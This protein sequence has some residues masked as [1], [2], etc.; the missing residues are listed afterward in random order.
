VLTEDLFD[1]FVEARLTLPFDQS[2]AEKQ[3]RMDAALAGFE[4][5]VA[6]QVSDVT[7]AATYYIAE[8]YFDFSQ[9]LLDSERPDDLSAAELVEY[10]LVLE[11]HAFPFEEQAIDVHEQNFALLANGVFNPWVARSLG[12]LSEVMPG[13]YAK[14]EIST[15]FV[16]SVDVYAY[17]SPG[18]PEV[19]SGEAVAEDA[20]GGRDDF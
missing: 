17:R 19:D 6:Y 9:S 3:Q 2:L 11:E 14:A 1:R 20:G 18:A 7:A 5:L 12:K 13:R 8:I 16:G 10:E 4:D 15:G